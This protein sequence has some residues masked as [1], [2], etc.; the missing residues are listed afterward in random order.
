LGVVRRGWPGIKVTFN[1]EDDIMKN[2]KPKTIGIWAQTLTLVFIA[3]GL[4]CASSSPTGDKA[5]AIDQSV[6][7]ALTRFDADLK[8]A[9]KL[10]RSAKGALVFPG[11]V[12]GGVIVGGEYGEG[13]LRIGGRTVNYYSIAA[14]S[15]GLQ[16]GAQKKD[17]IILFMDQNALNNFQNSQGWTVGV[18]GNIT[19]VTLAAG[20]SVDTMKLNQPILGFVVGQTGLMGGISLQGSKITKLQP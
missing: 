8:G 7:A 11:V 14:A 19:L 16:L 3:F 18:D 20:A 4:G 1:Q 5:K 15:F 13:A 9:D 12:Q 2:V 6:N 17:I 10:V